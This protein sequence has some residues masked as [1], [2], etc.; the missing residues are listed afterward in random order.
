[1]V[2]AAVVVGKGEGVEAGGGVGD[3]DDA[4]DDTQGLGAGGVGDMLDRLGGVGG[5]GDVVECLGGN[6]LVAAAG[7][8]AANLFGGG[9]AGFIGPC[10]GVTTVGG[11][12]VLECVGAGELEGAVVDQQGSVVLLFVT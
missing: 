4:V 6:V 1:M 7:D 5:V 10:V 8:A 9:G 12:G 2:G 3:G 11:A